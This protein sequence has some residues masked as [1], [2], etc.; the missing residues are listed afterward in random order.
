ML[1]FSS[2]FFPKCSDE[3]K[4]RTKGHKTGVQDLAS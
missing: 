2:F 1:V 4:K 3:K